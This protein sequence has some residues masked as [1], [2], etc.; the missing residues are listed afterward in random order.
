MDI[1]PDENEDIIMDNFEKWKEKNLFK[2]IGAALPSHDPQFNEYEDFAKTI[3][4][5]SAKQ[6]EKWHDIIKECEQ[7][8]GCPDTAESPLMCNLPNLIRDLIHREGNKAIFERK[9][10]VD[11]IRE[12]RA[13]PNDIPILKVTMAESVGN[14]SL[15]AL[16]KNYIADRIEANNR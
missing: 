14:L 3:W 11:D 15:F 16:I 4:Q 1:G 10:I 7:L 2:L 5:E 13:N 12:M 6:G 9:R 8:L